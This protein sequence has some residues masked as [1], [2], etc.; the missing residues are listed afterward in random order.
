MEISAGIKRHLFRPSLFWRLLS[1]YVF[2][3]LRLFYGRITV[4]GREHIPDQGPLLFAP[5]HQNALMDPL[6]VLHA[7]GR[8]IVFL[9]RADIFRSP[10]LRRIF[11]W[12]KILP[13]YRIR[14]GKDSLQHNEQSFA[15][16][17]EVLRHGQAV[18]IFPEAAHASQWRLLPLRKGVPRVAFLAEEAHAF[19][20]GVQIVPVGVFYDQYEMSG[21]RVHLRFGPAISV[22]AYA[23][24][25]RENPQKAM[26]ALRDAIREGLRPLTI[27]VPDPDT[28]DSYKFALDV[29]APELAA[30]PIHRANQTDPV[31]QTDPASQTRRANQTDPAS[32]LFEARQRIIA[33]LHDLAVREPARRQALDDKLGVLKQRLQ[34]LRLPPGRLFSRRP[35]PLAL[36]CHTLAILPALPL[37]LYGLL[38]HLPSRLLLNRLLKQ[39]QD[40]QFISSVKFVWGIL[41]QPLLYLLQIL[42]LSLLI[43]VEGF[44]WMYALSLPLSG[45]FLLWARPRLL[46]LK[47][48]W[49]WWGIRHFRPR[50]HHA[51]MALKNSLQEDFSRIF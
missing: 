31:S 8:Q 12:M 5:N 10:W 30:R 14:D 44:W 27:H 9:A 46:A 47:Q 20:L 16:A 35:A 48:A 40:R 22:A 32:K 15:L 51:L 50:D 18:G 13:V 21:A 36:L 29:Y 33:A 2:G 3:M 37:Y 17:A 43:R 28:Y 38:N 4:A 42:L 1:H 19:K 25:Y 49:R 45:F 7:S 6:L 41:V 39:F 23:G 34:A 11:L 24:M 26:L